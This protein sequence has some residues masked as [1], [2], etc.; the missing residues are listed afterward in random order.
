MEIIVG[1]CGFPVRRDMYCRALRAVEVQTTFYNLP[2]VQT[3]RRWREECPPPFRFTMKAWQLITHPPSSP[4]YRRLRKPLSGDPQAYGY[5]RPT[6]EVWAAWL[7]TRE[8]AENLGVEWVI[9]QSPRSFTP[10]EEHISNLRTFFSRLERGSWRVGWEPRGDWPDAVVASICKEFG[11]THVVDPFVRLPVT[12]E[13]AY[14]R[15]HGRTGYRYKYTEE[16]LKCLLDRVRAY[17]ESWVFFNN[18]Y[19]WDDARAFQALL[20][21]GRV[22]DNS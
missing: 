7:Q 1:C 22:T 17:E 10:T 9:F 12:R 19:M 3:V 6:P 21:E 15:L 2:R 4:T 16:D 8:I 5:F 20:G 11:I 18:V 13:V 14:F